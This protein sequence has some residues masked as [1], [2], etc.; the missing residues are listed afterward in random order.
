MKDV[1][2]AFRLLGIDEL[3]LDKLE[4][5][6]LRILSEAGSMKLNVI[7]SKLEL[8]RQTVAA[9]I[10]TSLI[11]LGLVEKG[12]TSERII[13]DRITKNT[14]FRYCGKSFFSRRSW[15]RLL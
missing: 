10:E 3:G 15:G 2:E 13:T 4:R 12:K 14:K 9:V 7:S 8:P 5:S 11:K 1:Q 6:Y